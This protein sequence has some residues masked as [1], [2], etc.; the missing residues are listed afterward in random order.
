MAGRHAAP[1]KRVE[2]TATSGA[3]VRVS[4][5]MVEEYERRGFRRAEAPRTAK[6]AAPRK[7]ATKKN[8]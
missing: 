8:N 6:K 1:L 2:M 3:P 7:R 5:S 4:E